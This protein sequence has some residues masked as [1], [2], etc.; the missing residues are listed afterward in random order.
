[1]SFVLFVLWQRTG[2]S[3]RSLIAPGLVLAILTAADWRWT[4]AAVG[5]LGFLW[6]P[7]WLFSTRRPEL[8]AVWSGTSA[9]RQAAQGRGSI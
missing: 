3:V 1:M 6:V 4:F 5:A 2:T 9:E 8:S 7:L